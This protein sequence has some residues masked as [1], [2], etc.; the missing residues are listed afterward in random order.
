[1]RKV[2]RRGVVVLLAGLSFVW[3]AWV[4]STPLGAGP[5]E[6]SQY[7]RALSVGG[8]HLLGTPAA[9]H[10][11]EVP[12]SPFRQAVFDAN[13]ARVSVPNRLQPEIPTLPCYAGRPAVPA[14]CASRTPPLGRSDVTY[15]GRYQPLYYLVP[16]IVALR[17]GSEP[18][19]LRAARVAGGLVC[20]ALL[21]LALCYGDGV[22]GVLLAVTPMTLSLAAT[23]TS[24]GFEVASAIAFTAITLAIADR[25]PTTGGLVAWVISGVCLAWSRPLGSAWVGFALVVAAIGFAHR[26]VLNRRDWAAVGALAIAGGGSVWWSEAVVNAV[27]S[28]HLSLHAK[29]HSATGTFW[30]TLREQVGQFGWLDVR[31]PSWCVIAWVA[32]IVALVGWGAVKGSGRQRLAIAISV[33]G[34]LVADYAINSHE[35][36]SAFTDQ[37]RYV[38]PVLAVPV[39]VAGRVLRADRRVLLAVGALFVVGNAVALY[40]NARRYAVGTN[41]SHVFLTGAAWTPAGGWWLWLVVALAGFGLIGVGLVTVKREALR[42]PAK[43]A[44]PG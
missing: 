33:V 32:G 23:V 20:I 29:V 34:Y 10:E 38:L 9:W 30:S 36:N 13:S 5:D 18:A 40:S 15:V 17:F 44:A 35:V 16:G 8:G 31:L 2:S 42:L 24:S 19:A 43:T 37:G 21:G 26:R 3:L 7:L 22:A 27:P 39:L 6:P 1:V 28:L 25:E 4:G 11:P 12:L 14:S 41:G